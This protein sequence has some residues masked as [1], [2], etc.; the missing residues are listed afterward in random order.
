MNVF[1]V[2]F[3]FRETIIILDHLKT[4]QLFLIETFLMM[5]VYVNTQEMGVNTHT[6]IRSSSRGV[7]GL[8]YSRSISLTSTHSNQK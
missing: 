6:D 5:N 7:K 8:L 4:D 1:C 2:N 3:R